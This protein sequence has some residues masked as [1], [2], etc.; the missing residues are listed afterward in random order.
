MALPEANQSGTKRVT[1]REQ[2]TEAFISVP[3][4]DLAGRLSREAYPE[5]NVIMPSNR[6]RR[7]RQL[8]AESSMSYQ[9]V[10][11]SLENR[12]GQENPVPW[13]IEK[14]AIALGEAARLVD[15]AN[16]PDT[17]AWYREAL[18]ATALPMIA[19][20]ANPLSQ[21]CAIALR[22]PTS[23]TSG[24]PSRQAEPQRSVRGSPNMT[25]NAILATA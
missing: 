4:H 2:A 19:R 9:A 3:R 23:R 12:G 6:K 18:K 24:S 5:R 17:N 15:L 11:N 10:L 14:T 25:S 21:S 1:P 16:E 22:P 13:L 7:I 8:M 20:L